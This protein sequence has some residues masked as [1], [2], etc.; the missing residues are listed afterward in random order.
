MA[1]FISIVLWPVYDTFYTKYFFLWAPSFPVKLQG[2][3]EFYR[4]LRTQLKPDK[5]HLFPRLLVVCKTSGGSSSV[6]HIFQIK[7]F[8][9]HT[10][11]F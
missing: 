6:C 10:L 3:N 4:N 2:L 8:F 9:H 11:H 7:S 5:G 1:E